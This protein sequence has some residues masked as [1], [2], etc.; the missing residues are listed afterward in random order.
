M[1]L[2]LVRPCRSL[3][4]RL[5]ECKGSAIL[6]MVLKDTDTELPLMVGLRL[7]TTPRGGHVGANVRVESL[8]DFR[9]VSKSGEEGVGIM[10][11]V[12][13]PAAVS[14]TLGQHPFQQ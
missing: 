4:L 10:M 11:I 7:A 1:V 3:S 6:G 9:V 14:N 13:L 12:C 5:G 8:L 2:D